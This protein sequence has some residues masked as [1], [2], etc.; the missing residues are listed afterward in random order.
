MNHFLMLSGVL[1]NPITMLRKIRDEDDENDLVIPENQKS[2]MKKPK[3]AP[4][5]YIK[6]EKGDSS[7]G[8]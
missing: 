2:I 6:Y 8:T 5:T 3:C 4:F 1:R 7:H